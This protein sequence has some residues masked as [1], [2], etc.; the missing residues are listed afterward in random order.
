MYSIC[1]R[2]FVFHPWCCFFQNYCLFLIEKFCFSSMHVYVCVSCVSS[3][4]SLC[5][6][7]VFYVCS[8]CLLCVFSVSLLWPKYYIFTTRWTKLLL[9]HCTHLLRFFLREKKKSAYDM[10]GYVSF[11]SPGVRLYVFGLHIC[12]YF[13]KYI[14]FCFC[15]T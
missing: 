15:I 10:S 8:L 6:L 1:H 14:Y 9:V 11:H 13:F 5:V 4:C 3:E 7:C 2:V 12:I